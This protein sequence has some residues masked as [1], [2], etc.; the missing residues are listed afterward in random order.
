MST[1]HFSNWRPQIEGERWRWPS[2]LI[3]EKTWVLN[4]KRP[5]TE[6]VSLIV[7]FFFCCIRVNYTF[8]FNVP[9]RGTECTTMLWPVWTE[10]S[11][12]TCKIMLFA[13]NSFSVTHKILRVHGVAVV[14]ILKLSWSS[15]LIWWAQRF[16]SVDVEEGEIFKVDTLVKPEELLAHQNSNV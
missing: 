1:K 5:R 4:K 7:S 16:G 8:Y 13:T 2:W 11:S 10:M 3:S 9:A 14:Y 15:V 12:V 6:H